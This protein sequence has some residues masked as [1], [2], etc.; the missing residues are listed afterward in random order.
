MINNDS[1][2]I[3]KFQK[4]F[5][6][7]L[8]FFYKIVT[9]FQ[10]IA[11]SKQPCCVLVLELIINILYTSYLYN[12][13]H[14]KQLILK[15]NIFLTFQRKCQIILL[16]KVIIIEAL[17]CLTSK[18]RKDHLPTI[19]C[20]LNLCNVPASMPTIGKQFQVCSLLL[21]RVIQFFWRVKQ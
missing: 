10:N 6:F 3:L 17:F 15:Q 8:F 16:H 2:L 5:F 19:H 13:P 7:V 20:L 18:T 14:M 1:V 4:W 9:S 11:V 12:N 21:K